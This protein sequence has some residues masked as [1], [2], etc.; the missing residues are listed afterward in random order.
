MKE[1][2]GRDGE[3]EAEF[4]EAEWV[5]R[6]QQGDV[7]AFDRLVAEYQGRIYALLY[8]MTSNRE[9]AE[10]LVQEVFV[11]AYKALPKFR[12]Q[13]SFY[14]W[15]YR[16]AV[17]RAI[18]FVKTRK[19]RRGLS[20]DDVD[21]AIERDPA[22]VELSGNETPLR[23]MKLAEMQEKL[24][25]A[26]QTLSENHRTVVVLHDIQ[27]LPHQEIGELL[28]C[29]TGTVRSRLFYARQQLQAQLSDLQS[30]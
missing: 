27:G 21:L 20:L 15:V 29:S 7:K 25:E 18:N 4:Q 23:Q 2:P 30:S 14:T 8:H 5:Q 3:P 26:L 10:D 11:K 16:I 13:S 19:R 9:D 22:L 12:G 1:E 28:G 17:N 24:N 6:A